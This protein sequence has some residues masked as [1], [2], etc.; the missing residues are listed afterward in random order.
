[1]MIDQFFRLQKSSNN[2]QV[3]TKRLQ[4][5]LQSEVVDRFVESRNSR[6]IVKL[7]LRQINYTNFSEIKKTRQN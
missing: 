2:N 6:S 3:K 1:M 5:P 7:S 4:P